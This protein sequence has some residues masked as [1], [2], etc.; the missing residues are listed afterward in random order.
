SG[1]VQGTARPIQWPRVHASAS[2]EGASPPIRRHLDLDLHLRVDEA[3]DDHR[4]RRA[5]FAEGLTED[6][7]DLRGVADVDDVVM[8]ADHV[9]EAETGLGKR[10][11]DDAERIPR[12]SLDG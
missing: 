5:D 7:G 10:L 3:A 4:R 9:G 1:L 11:A 2:V 6:R 8:D 12:L